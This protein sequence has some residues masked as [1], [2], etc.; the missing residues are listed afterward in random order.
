MK[1]IRVLLVED[2]PGDA[3]LIKEMLAEAQGLEFNLEWVSRLADGLHR[4]DRD[5]ADVVLLDLGLPDSQGLDTV[6]RAYRQAPEVPF[7]VLT[8]LSD[9]TLALAALRTG[10]QDYLFKDEASPHLLLRAIRYATE[11]KRAELALKAERNKLYAVL[12]SLPA[13]VHLKDKNLA[14][15]FANRNFMEVFGDPGNKRCY[16]VLCGRDEICDNCRAQE[17]LETKIPQKFEWASPFLD[18]VFEVH[19]Y[20]LCGD[21]GMEVLT[22]GIDITERKKAEEGLRQ[23]EQNLRYLASRLLDAQERERI[24]IAHELHDDLGQ[25]LFV[26][27]MQI[28]YIARALPPELEKLRQ[29]CF[30][31]TKTVL[32]IINSV[33]RLSHDLIPPSLKEIGLR[34]ALT[35]LL[36]EFSR[37]H[38]IS[39]SLDTD[40][41]RDRFPMDAK[42]NIY[43]IVQECLTNVGKYSQATN[44]HVSI[45]IK[46][47]EILLTV[48]DNGLGFEVDQILT[49]RGSR[50]GLGLSSMEERARLMG[51]T[52][53]LWSKPNEGTRIQVIVPL[54]NEAAGSAWI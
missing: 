49:R 43:R 32:E 14:I 21:D 23:S 28:A 27:K 6:I 18:R 26:L 24:R 34:A 4:L 50:R 30:E 53:H 41:L 13:F 11:R 5:S 39:Y 25:S 42:L 29:E 46:D 44:V 52:F 22:L 17:I 12:D 48:E 19:N 20:P 33:R 16:E 37:Y 47:H 9:D 45:K 36:K 15:K 1:P 3:R 35:D 38:N 31:S 10:A 51:G 7:V 40:E 2:N 8:G 54:K